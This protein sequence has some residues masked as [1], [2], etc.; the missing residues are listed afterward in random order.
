[1]EKYNSKQSKEN[2]FIS[3][4][5]GVN[6]DKK[7]GV[8]ISEVS[9]GIF[10]D[11]ENATK[12]CEMGL[13]EIEHDLPHFVKYVDFGGGT[14]FLTKIVKDW[15]EKNGHE[16]QA[17]VADANNEYL[18]EATN[19]GLLG[20]LCNLTDTNFS[21]LDL[22]TMRSVLHYNPTN[23]QKIIIKKVF[24]S[25]KEGAF[26]MNQIAMGEEENNKLRC[27]I[28]DALA[29][30]YWISYEEYKKMLEDAGFKDIQISDSI[31][32]TVWGPEN[33]WKR[34]NGNH[35]ERAIKDNDTEKIHLLENQRKK[36]LETTNEIIEDSY[37]KKGAGLGIERDK[38]GL[39]K[40]RNQFKI[41]TCR[42]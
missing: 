7:G 40:I 18:E 24:E 19:K 17:T 20:K 34:Y 28:S 14:G 8:N 3:D 11:A 35:L 12:F 26:F 27:Q 23:I 31:C 21:D 36:Y 15:L 16:V 42:K 22:A 25:L 37:K 39:Y 10:S 9:G 13:K 38:N 32:D 5:P 33:V 29:K 6:A 41:V 2:N 1:M 30:K 4:S